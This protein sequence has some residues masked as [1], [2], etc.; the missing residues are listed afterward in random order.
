MVNDAYNARDNHATTPEAAQE[1]IAAVLGAMDEDDED[2]E[3]ANPPAEF[4]YE[5]ANEED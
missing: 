3:D 1:N 2:G 5:S 4:D